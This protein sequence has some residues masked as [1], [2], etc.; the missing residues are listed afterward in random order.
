MALSRVIVLMYTNVTMPVRYPNLAARWQLCEVQAPHSVHLSSIK[1]QEFN[2][3]NHVV[4]E[5]L[6]MN[7]TQYALTFF[8]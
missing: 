8:Y 5:L 2:S 4:S 1:L 3:T 6:M 7:E